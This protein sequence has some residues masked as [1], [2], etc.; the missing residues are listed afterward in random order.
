MASVVVL[1]AFAFLVAIAVLHLMGMRRLGCWLIVILPVILCAQGLV[2]ISH[3]VAK[4]GE[5][6]FRSDQKELTYSF[7]LLALSLFAAFRPKSPWLFWIVWAFNIAVC[8]I[9]F[10]LIFFWKVFN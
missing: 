2:D 7:G 5:A 1:A 3:G 10:Y 8:G 6:S 9:L 4:L